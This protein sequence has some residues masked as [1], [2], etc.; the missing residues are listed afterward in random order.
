[1]NLLVF[2][3]VVV[4]KP[5]ALLFP[6]KFLDKVNFYLHNKLSDS[7]NNFRIH[8]LAVKKRNLKQTA[9]LL[10]ERLNDADNS[11][12]TQCYLMSLDIIDYKIIE[13]PPLGKKRTPPTDICKIFF[14]RFL[15]T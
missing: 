4:H 9:I 12:Y 7:P 13:P 5:N 14:D 2:L 8:L 10:N 15:M 11:L 3:E 1:M 6:D